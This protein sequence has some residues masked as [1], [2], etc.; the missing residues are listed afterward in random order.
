MND[1]NPV[2]GNI[3]GLFAAQFLVRTVILVS[4]TVKRRLGQFDVV[5]FNRGFAVGADGQNILGFSTEHNLPHGNGIRRHGNRHF[6]VIND[7]ELK[8]VGQRAGIADVKRV[9]IVGKNRF[10]IVI[11]NLIAFNQ[12]HNAENKDN[13]RSNTNRKNYAV[14][15][16]DVTFGMC[17][18]FFA[19]WVLTTL[20]N[21]P[22]RPR[23]LQAESPASSDLTGPTR[24]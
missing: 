15:F 22:L 1:R 14:G 16:F 3:T 2:H 18:Y 11:N 19:H 13:K 5:N 24:R 9:V 12:K 8:I 21:T 23:R 20:Q 7:T 6:A 10:F 4:K 17:K